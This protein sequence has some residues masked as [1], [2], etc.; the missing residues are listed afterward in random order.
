MNE[1]AG[2]LSFK[3]VS[4]ATITGHDG[5]VMTRQWTHGTVAVFLCELAVPAQQFPQGNPVM[6]IF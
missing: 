5:T 6:P 1:L 4:D 3:D 2:L